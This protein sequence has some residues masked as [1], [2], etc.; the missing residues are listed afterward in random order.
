MPAILH[1]QVVQL[2]LRLRQSA[3]AEDRDGIAVVGQGMGGG[4]AIAQVLARLMLQVSVQRRY[5]AAEVGKRTLPRFRRRHG[6]A[7]WRDLE[8]WLRQRWCKQ[9]DFA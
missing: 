2:Q 3:I 7:G 1:L 5:A 4:D 8:I 6:R 9:V